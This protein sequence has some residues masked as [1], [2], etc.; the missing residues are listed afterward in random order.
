MEKIFIEKLGKVIKY[1]KDIEK[2]LKVT[3][4][5]T[6]EGVEI[7]S[8]SD[9]AYS[10]FIAKSVVEALNSGFSL[11]SALKLR[12]EDY[13]MQTISVKS[14]ARPQRIKTIIGR[15]IGEKG[16]TKEIIAEMTGC[17]IAIHD[18]NVSVIGDTEDVELA[19]HAIRSLIQGS[20]H[21]SVYAYLERN[22]KFRKYKTED[23][24]LKEIK[25]K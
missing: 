9:D 11:E 20:P 24:G 18:Y 22:R 8:K 4:K 25:K 15:L 6:S 17:D 1:K 5:T 2:L 21:A 23:L 10:E 19:A 12:N 3:L 16:R 13:M 7:E 14:H